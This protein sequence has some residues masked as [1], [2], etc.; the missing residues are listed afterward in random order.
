MFEPLL[1]SVGYG[2]LGLTISYLYCK[3]MEKEL[4][5][6]PLISEGS[7]ITIWTTITTTAFGF[8]YGI[9]KLT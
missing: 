4:R 1:Y 2:A 5:I 6:L 9:A 8:G 3:V 7:F